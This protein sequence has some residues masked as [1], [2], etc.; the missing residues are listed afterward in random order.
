M[1]PATLALTAAGLTLAL[2]SLLA[3]S[4]MLPLR[5]TTGRGP[6]GYYTII[7]ENLWG[8]SLTWTNWHE[9]LDETV[10]PPVML[11]FWESGP[12]REEQREG[13]WTL[14]SK[15]AGDPSWSERIV[16]YLHGREVSEDEWDRR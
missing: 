16:W 14:K 9:Y 12:Y 8:Q 6:G 13:R 5:T 2:G 7:N 4:L 15:H 3:A 1:R 10:D 11:E